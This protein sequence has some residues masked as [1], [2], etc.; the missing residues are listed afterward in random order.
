MRS[1][2]R[3]PAKVKRLPTDASKREAARKGEAASKPSSEVSAGGQPPAERARRRAVRI[4]K[5]LHTGGQPPAGPVNRRARLLPNGRA[6][7]SACKGHRTQNGDARVLF[8][9][10]GCGGR[11]SAR[12]RGVI[13]CACALPPCLS[14]SPCGSKSRSSRGRWRGCRRIQTRSAAK[15]P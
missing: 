6:E 11:H 10:E 15:A 3:P 5:R 9:R 1:S 14:A 4:F 13:P 8:L 12:L 2:E 7:Q